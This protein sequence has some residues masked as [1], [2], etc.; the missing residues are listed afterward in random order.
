MSYAYEVAKAE[1]QLV[2]MVP[3]TET[4]SATQEKSKEW[5]G[6]W[7]RHHQF[8]FTSKLWDNDNTSDIF[9]AF[10]FKPQFFST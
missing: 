5:T 3:H 6:V 10:N 4:N 1:K 2:T 8:L 7:N 9:V